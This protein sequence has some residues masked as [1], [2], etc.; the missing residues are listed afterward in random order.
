MKAQHAPVS[1]LPMTSTLH[2]PENGK[3]DLR[4]YE[5][6]RIHRM[7][8]RCDDRAR[9]WLY[10]WNDRFRRV[11][12]AEFG[13]EN[14]QEVGTWESRAWRELVWSRG[15]MTSAEWRSVN[16]RLAAIEAEMKRRG[17]PLND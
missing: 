7:R 3:R 13:I 9:R 10:V 15:W 12:L 2:Q 4:S 1:T 11:P 14:V 5:H 8:R 17:L 6:A 16:R